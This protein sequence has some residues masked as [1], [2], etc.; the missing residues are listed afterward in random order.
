MKRQEHPLFKLC[1]AILSSV[2]KRRRGG[3]RRVPFIISRVPTAEKILALT[4]NAD[5]S[6]KMETDIR[7]GKV[8]QWYDSSIIPLLERLQVPSTFFLTGRWA[9]MYPNV[10]REIAQSEFFEIANHGFSHSGLSHISGNLYNDRPS[11]EDSVKSAEKILATYP[12][13]RKFFRFERGEEDLEAS[14]GIRHLE[15]RIIGASINGPDLNVKSP[16]RIEHKVLGR[17][18]Q[19]AIIALHLGGGSRTPATGRAL[20]GIIEKAR[21][22]G[23]RFV[24][25]SELLES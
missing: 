8:R 3:K 9:Q 21:A 11:V 20:R 6:P 15:Y 19:G 5:M 25:L 2:F 1:A 23:F 10:V 18:H 4:W 16:N 14:A 7:F 17:L 24:K 12:S 22:R 13:Y